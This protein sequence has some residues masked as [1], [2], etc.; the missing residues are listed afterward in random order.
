MDWSYELLEDEDKTLFAR[1]SVF[2]GG[3]TLEAIEEICDPEGDLD[4]LEGVESLVEKSLLRQEE[5]SGGAAPRFV[6][7]ETVH[8]YAREKLLESGEVEEVKKRHAE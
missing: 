5:G 6:M 4:A 3:R 1:I 2:A 8:E 7:L